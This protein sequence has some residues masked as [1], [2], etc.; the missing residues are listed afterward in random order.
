MAGS[1]LSRVANWRRTRGNPRMLHVRIRDF[2]LGLHNLF[3]YRVFMTLRCSQIHRARAEAV[4]AWGITQAGGSLDAYGT[5]QPGGTCGMN[6]HTTSAP[7]IGSTP[8]STKKHPRPATIDCA[9]PP[10]AHIGAN[11]RDGG[12]ESRPQKLE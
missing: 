4:E 11:P 6:T 5:P 12:H 8:A 3:H 1:I 2:F 9:S 7:G 10:G